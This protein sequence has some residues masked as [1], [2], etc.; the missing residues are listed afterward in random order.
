MAT[1]AQ[2][3]LDQAATRARIDASR[4]N[5]TVPEPAMTLKARLAS[6]DRIDRFAQITQPTPVAA[7]NASELIKVALQARVGKDTLPEG[8]A[9]DQA[10]MTPFELRD[11]YGDAE[12]NAMLAEVGRGN[13]LV[14][15]VASMPA[16]SG[17][18]IAKDATLDVTRSFTN[19]AGGIGALGAS[20]YI[21]PLTGGG[22]VGPWLARKTQEWDEG[23]KSVQSEELQDRRQ[24]NEVYGQLLGEDNDR[25]VERDR[26]DGKSDF[27]TSMRQI[28]RG[29]LNAGDRLNEDSTVSIS[30][31]ISAGASMLA[32]GPL[33]RGVSGAIQAPVNA[34]VRRGLMA[35]P[36]R[37]SVSTALTLE[38][39]GARAGQMAA[40]P[41]A[42]GLM[43]AGSGFN[44]TANDV[45]S[46]SPEELQEGS[47][48]YRELRAKG[49]SHEDAKLEIAQDAA[50]LASLGTGLVGGATGRLVSGFEGKGIGGLARAGLTRVTSREAVEEGIQGAAQPFFT[51]TAINELANDSREIGQDVGE[52]LAEGAILGSLSAGVLA[53]PGASVRGTVAAAKGATRAT[54]AGAKAVL[55]PLVNRGERILNEAADRAPLSVKSMTN[56]ANIAVEKA[57]AI[58]ETVR[59]AF[60]KAVASNPTVAEAA[61]KSSEAMK[62]FLARMPVQ[63][64]EIAALPV[65]EKIKAVVAGAR[66]RFDL[67]NQLA[68]FIESSKSSPEEKA[69]AA[70][71]LHKQLQENDDAGVQSLEAYDVLEDTEEGKTVASEL[72]RYN[73]V[74]KGLRNTPVVQNAMGKIKEIMAK[75]KVTSAPTV[76]NINT[77]VAVAEVAPDKIDP[78]AIDGL[79]QEEQ[80]GTIQLS[81][82]QRNALMTARNLAR[83]AMQHQEA[84]AKL[85]TSP[86]VVTDQILTETTGKGEKQPS[87][88]EHARIITDAMRVG[89]AESATKQFQRLRNLGETLFNKVAAINQ[90]LQNGDGQQSKGIQYENFTASGV[91]RKSQTR[92][93]VN[94][95]VPSTIDFAQ[96]VENDAR[97]VAGIVNSLTEIYPELGIEKLQVTSLAPELKGDPVEA[98][99]RN[100]QAKAKPPV[101]APVAETIE[102]A[103][104]SEAKAE[105][106]QTAEEKTGFTEEQLNQAAKTEVELREQD[107]QPELDL[108]APEPKAKPEPKAEPRR[109]VLPSAKPS[110]EP[111][112]EATP[113][114]EPAPVE[115]VEEKP[116]RFAGLKGYFTKAF[117]PS[118]NERSRLVD[119]DRPVSKIRDVLSSAEKFV[120][121]LGKNSRS[122]LTPEIASNYQ[123]LMKSSK[124]LGETLNKQLNAR[125]SQV[126]DGKTVEQH[127]FDGTLL[128]RKTDSKD[129]RSKKGDTY[130]I[131]LKPD[132]KSLNLLIE[133]DGKLVYDPAL[134][135]GAILAGLQWTLVA[136]RYWSKLDTEKG[137]EILGLSEAQAEKFMDD[138]RAGLGVIETKKSLANM[139]QQFWGVS[140]NRDTDEALSRGIA[141]S[142]ASEVLSAMVENDLIGS[143]KFTVT[144][145]DGLKEPKKDFERFVPMDLKGSPIESYPSAIEEAVLID[146][147]PEYH[148]GIPPQRVARTQM[149]NPRVEN[150]AEARKAIEHENKTPYLANI[151][152]I[153]LWQS[154]GENMMIRLFGHPDIDKRPLNV[155]HKAKL[156]GQNLT[157]T[158][159]I[160]T[161]GR[162][163]NQL[164][165]W[166]NSNG[167]TVEE[168]QV[169][170]DHNMSK[171]GRMQQLGRNSPQASKLVRE[172]YLPM[173][174]TLD[175]SDLQGDGFSRYG[176]ALAQALGEKVDRSL[177]ADTVD[178]ILVKLEAEYAPAVEILTRWHQDPFALTAKDVDTIRESLGGEV[179]PMGFHALFDYARY[180][181]TDAEGRKSFTT[182]LYVEADG[183]ANGISNAI[184]MT[185]SNH[186]DEEQIANMAKAGVFLRN[187]QQTMNQ[188][189]QSVNVDLYGT[190]ANRLYEIL[191]GERTDVGNQINVKLLNNLLDLLETVGGGVKT[192][193]DEA[194]EG[195]TRREYDR[196]L[197]KNPATITIYG[198]GEKG[199]AGNIVNDLLSKVY[200]RMS[201]ASEK[202]AADKSLS[203]AD[204]MFKDKAS[205]DQ[206]SEQLLNDFVTKL[207]ELGSPLVS[208]ANGV[209]TPKINPETFKVSNE[210][211]DE[212]VGHV[213]AL[214]VK[215][216]RQVISDTVGQS[217]MNSMEAIRIAGQSQGI[218]LKY[219]YQA[220]FLK[221][222][223]G[224][225]ADEALSPKE[226]DEVFESLS[227]LS[228]VIDTGN[229]RFYPAGSQSSEF[230]QTEFGRALSGKYRTSS[231]FNLP[232]N[233]GVRTMPMMV[234]GNG[235]AFMMQ[236]MA[237]M[238][239][240]VE[241]TIKI[242][243]GVNVALHLMDE[244]SRQAN[245]AAWA[246]MMQNPVANVLKSYRT[247]MQNADFNNTTNEQHAELV[248]ALLGFGA[249]PA[250]ISRA[251][252]REL[253][254]NL[255]AEMEGISQS[256]EARHRVLKRVK[257]SVDQM[258]AVGVP[259]QQ[260]GD[261]DLSELSEQEA[262]KRL[263]D[264]LRA[265]LAKIRSETAQEATEKPVQAQPAEEA[266]NIADELLDASR[267]LGNGIRSIS[268]T[269]LGRMVPKLKI[270]AG[271]KL[272]LAE[273]MR[274]LSV[275]GYR[276]INGSIDNIRNW[277]TANGV[278][279][280]PIREGQVQGYISFADKIIYT[281]NATSE[282]LTHELIHAATFET[283]VNGYTGG[284]FGENGQ[285]VRDAIKR[286]EALANQFVGLSKIEGQIPVQAED[287]YNN[288]RAAMREHLRKGTPVGKAAA[289]NEFMAWA[290][291]NQELMDLLSQ[292]EAT[293][294]ARLAKD[295]V[296]A[297]KKLIW[298]KRAGLP[299][300]DDMLSNLQFNAGIL[301]NSAPTVQEIVTEQGLFQNQT[302]GTDERLTKIHQTFE[303]K[304]TAFM[305]VD[306]IL[307]RDRDRRHDDAIMLVNDIVRDAEI[308]FPMNMQESG[309]FSVIVGALAL[310]TE[311]D[312]NSI[313]EVGKL[314]A[315]VIK[316]L[317]PE[318]FMPENSTDPLV[319]R[320]YAQKKF[321]FIV[322]R[323]GQQKDTYNRSTLLPVFLG[324]ATVNEDFR[325]VLRSVPVP[326]TELNKWDSVDNVL[327]NAGTYLMDKLSATVSGADRD[328][329]NVASAIAVLTDHIVEVAQDKQ[330]WIDTVVTKGHGVVDTI[331]DAFV[332]AVQQGAETVIARAQQIQAATNNRLVQG[333]AKVAE[334]TASLIH[335]R[336]AGELAQGFMSMVN[337]TNLPKW[338]S[339]LANEVV[340]RTDSNASVYDMIKLVRARVQQLRQVF[341]EDLPRIIKSRFSR[342]LKKH[343]WTHLFKM[344]KADL[345]AL[346][347]MTEDQIVDLFKTPGAVTSKVTD[348]EQ[349]VSSLAGS[350]WTLIQR[351]S[352]ELAEFM[353]TGKVPWKMLRNAKA[354]ASLHGEGVYQPGRAN[355]SVALIQAIDNL[356]SLYAIEGLNQET[357]ANLETL[358]NSEA[359]GMSF[360]ISYL[361]G[362]RKDELDKVSRSSLAEANH[363]KG[364]MPSE[365]ALGASLIV[366]EISK[367][368]QLL[369]RGYRKVA[370]Y[371]GSRGEG[372]TVRKAYYFS[373][374]SGRGTFNQ[375]IIQNVR[376]TAS[377]VDPLTGFT[378]SMITAGQITD[379][380]E[381]SMIKRRLARNDNTLE[382]L[383]PLYDETGEVIAY[384]RAIDPV[385]DAKLGRNT[386]IAEMIGAWHGRQIE[387]EQS[388]LFNRVLAQ[389]AKALWTSEKTLKA[390]EYVNLFGTLTDPVL[391]DAVSLMN[392]E[393]RD[394]IESQFG[395]DQFWV[396]K[397]MLNDVMGYRN[398]SLGDSWTG[399]SRWPKPTQEAFKKLATGVFGVDAY[400]YIMLAERG[401]QNLVQ[402]AKVLIVIKSVIVPVANLAANFLQLLSRGVPVNDILRGM[403]KKTAEIQDYMESRRRLIEVEAELRAVG[404]N[405]DKRN[406]LQ[407][408]ERAINDSHRRLSIW[409]LINAGEFASISDVTITQEQLTLSEGRLTEFV[410]KLTS[411]LPG[412][413]QTLG[414]YA[415]ISRDTA[416]FQGL[417][418]A[419]QY[420]DFLGKAVL[421]DHL[422]KK[423]GESHE[424][425]M[426]R[427]TEEF[428]NY[429]RLP[430]RTRGALETN[431][432]MWFWHFKLRSMKVGM[433][434]IRN[435]PVHALLAMSIPGLFGA[436]LPG[437]PITDNAGAIFLDPQRSAYSLG[438]DQM[439]QAH[440][441]NPWYN[442]IK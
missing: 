258:A 101:E 228:P 372:N 318:S 156:K 395:K 321:D 41:T 414:R 148:V 118:S 26:A 219:A 400:R 184:M 115:K 232:E 129:G 67:V 207:F 349:Q 70:A 221:R 99:R 327:E 80:K 254:T 417:Q 94:A 195:G 151:P 441:L 427:I 60:E 260:S 271:Q 93:W 302:F 410:E 132:G 242:F 205:T 90:H 4:D 154:M 442:L 267:D 297:I 29:I 418:R 251:D 288:T 218:F 292:K 10:T 11:K 61:Q 408:E 5:W 439:I 404:S 153:T 199:I 53:A 21:D 353:N 84:A 246:A 71:E 272:M 391:K 255:V 174:S 83:V 330:M 23:Q 370:E 165:H 411:K 57:P 359:A 385:H 177:R 3:L 107:R 155:E 139:I 413:V 433:S 257:L 323:I 87:A 250:K 37:M 337:K 241:Q 283:L 141:E 133:Q 268:R 166:A 233:P 231:Y 245:E 73:E 415:I 384:E 55:Q 69:E 301:I 52:G 273:I 16:R 285:I 159:A 169:F 274:S 261:I 82:Y 304:I 122:E 149:N 322:G 33:A 377:G 214:F 134:L 429:D 193:V 298:G 376:E 108:R 426:A 95:T 189:R 440:F 12:A 119:V 14:G 6:E 334:I 247:F 120:E 437:S 72:K 403:P 311:L 45:M 434:I 364:Y 158:S 196:G 208:V 369:A 345:G 65:R 284:S 389:R 13:A 49:L 252:V 146:H 185:N 367:E 324:L 128:T 124:G 58:Y 313:N 306:P 383:M 35:G 187:P 423:K 212:M 263:N 102:A 303:R 320:Y 211:F 436:E 240:A 180:K 357:K 270:P 230:G 378:N 387:E 341:R 92:A 161:V 296:D 289:L 200:E 123:S 110:S 355:P 265:E 335:D 40:V 326:K 317:T 419:I 85:K 308:H 91:W 31:T 9:R 406:K 182:Q 18:E 264:E 286:I 290:L 398:A 421:Y 362:Q 145:E 279:G 79:L 236:T 43:E 171:V 22:S 116:D 401:W 143:H 386:N 191:S 227:G 168:A 125:L 112:A 222:M 259:F 164:E 373:P 172:V 32:V 331:N 438:L 275:K 66:T 167:K 237:T 396:R 294:L 68:T 104:P 38:A 162:L 293:P 339:D 192:V 361:I 113:A 217:V 204:A 190:A 136:G 51:N 30:D 314:Y 309:T 366:E 48:F 346:Q 276:V 131:L 374:V 152:L 312:P 186:F 405:T 47:E 238:K 210:Q 379:P 333:G 435:N 280:P 409:P 216:L 142:M 202:M 235:D 88:I 316:E 140:I 138:L 363:Y 188:H 170:F 206:T 114:P 50:R 381:V 144:R 269:E 215:P 224:K 39:A 375:G 226:Q 20:L 412:P 176:L 336:K 399:I 209:K 239:N 249:K 299:V 197:I 25:R 305:D 402:D 173:K 78:N 343:E 100:A 350:N 340:G 287:A 117:K 62:N 394:Y 244:S 178:K 332:G 344:A 225:N 266:G 424:Q 64:D 223:E 130:D 428:V 81:D 342:E 75:A 432:L 243:D 147:E 163:I 203:F 198:S 105:P 430:G 157:L 422:T 175:L 42:I 150:T 19:I 135:G 431:G 160:T 97:A 179:E 347:G 253:M 407:A 220:E 368:G 382:T 2:D 282:T 46:M 281:A 262:V 54:I 96:R 315:H 229:Q 15:R 329:P 126:L 127:I 106:E 338:M 356:V 416:L 325:R 392:N 278:Q 89:D 109:E 291:S 74:L 365:A 63:P 17:W 354:I 425:A 194:A 137:A 358:A 111:M 36:N 234:I 380:N 300:A 360:M 98:A 213:H 397:D 295:V 28:G 310:Q 1:R 34:A 59:G 420:G 121:F 351:K 307:M 388:R 352:K 319:D 390:D 183:V 77:A 348:A 328:A 8:R 103:P 181:A 76:E 7:R 86:S 393:T 201:E 24:V 56:A 248:Q 27:V 256:I 277:A 44:A 371:N